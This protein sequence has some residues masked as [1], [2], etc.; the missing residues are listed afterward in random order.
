MG[1]LKCD[2]IYCVAA[3]QCAGPIYTVIIK[4]LWPSL[5]IDVQRGI[6]SAVAV[7]CI[8]GSC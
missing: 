7:V 1:V 4:Y 2:L 5:G 8:G 6:I 3:A